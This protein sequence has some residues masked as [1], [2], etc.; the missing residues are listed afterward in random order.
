ML[1]RVLRRTF[2]KGRL[3]QI[4]SM[5]CSVGGPPAGGG[6]CGAPSKGGAACGATAPSKSGYLVKKGFVNVDNWFVIKEGEPLMSAYKNETETYQSIDKMELT[7]CDM[8]TDFGMSPPALVLMQG[9]KKWT[10]QLKDEG[11]ML[12]WLKALEK[13]GVNCMHPQEQVCD[14]VSCSPNI[15]GFELNDI[16]GSP[17]KLDK[18]KGQVTLIVNVASA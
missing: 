2:D 10:L 15:Y 9:K 14:E 11:D 17:V 3:T 7:G 1:S 13:S 18:Y 16:Y 6:S 5:S 12:P 4:Q 8:L